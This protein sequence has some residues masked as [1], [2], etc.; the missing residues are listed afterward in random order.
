MLI[1]KKGRLAY[2]EPH[3]T[4]KARLAQRPTAAGTANAKAGR[5]GSA[6]GGRLS[7]TP[8]GR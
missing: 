5:S 4:G 8:P 7:G 3:A 2:Y 6:P 1:G